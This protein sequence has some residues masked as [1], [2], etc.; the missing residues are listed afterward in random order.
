MVWNRRFWFLLSWKFL[1]DYSFVFS[2]RWSAGNWFWMR[3]SEVRFSAWPLARHRDVQLHPGARYWWQLRI[4]WVSL[5]HRVHR[6]LICWPRRLQKSIAWREIPICYN[7]CEPISTNNE[8][9]ENSVWGIWRLELHRY[10][11]HHTRGKQYH[12]SQPRSVCSSIES[13]VDLP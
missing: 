9:C 4:Q 11:G 3:G 6:L 1:S 13:G 2:F 10:P 12:I 5:S 8:Q 7:K